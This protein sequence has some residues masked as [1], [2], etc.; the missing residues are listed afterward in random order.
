MNTFLSLSYPLRGF[1][2]LWNVLLILTMIYSISYSVQKKRNASLIAVQAVII[3]GTFVLFE[4]LFHLNMVGHGI[5]DGL[6]VLAIL[7]LLFIL[8][9]V[10]FAQM[11]VT[12][13]SDRRA[14]NSESIREAINRLPAG[15]C[16]YY[17]G[18]LCKLV[19]EK[20]DGICRE[21]TEKGLR[22]GE[23][24]WEI[25]TT[26]NLSRGT[27]I[28]DGDYPIVIMPGGTVIYFSR[29]E[30]SFDGVTM[31]EISAADV[32]EEYELTLET[33]QKEAALKE[34]NRRLKNLGEEIS[35]LAVEKEILNSKMRLHDSWGQTLLATKKYLKNPSSEDRQA[36]YRLWDKNLLLLADENASSYRDIY[37]E[38]FHSAR[39]LGIKVNVTGQLPKEA[40][41]SRIACQALTTALSNLVRHAGG[42]EM[43]VTST[44]NDG[45]YILT[46]TNNGTLP[47]GPIRETGGLGTLRRLV[48]G[49]GGKMEVACTPGFE[50]RI[51]LGEEEYGI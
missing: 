9:L 45:K 41:A 33:E 19:N 17:P 20:M 16:C 13:T 44:K 38:V 37:A 15:I 1:L 4:V 23:A 31:F 51:E 34:I 35:K 21:L 26:G 27:P 47:E 50:L 2:M 22:D 48:E 28:Q 10:C 29:D 25:L 43:Y 39:A 32:T 8:S 11:A 3:A 14:I 36:M 6:P 40:Q 7:A 5:L 42:T 46:F 18:G 12:I 24:F 49:N 30:I